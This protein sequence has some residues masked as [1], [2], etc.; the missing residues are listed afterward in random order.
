LPMVVANGTAPASRDP[1]ARV[2]ELDG[3]APGKT[4]YECYFVTCAPSLCCNA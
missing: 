1:E 3:A 4:D 2:S